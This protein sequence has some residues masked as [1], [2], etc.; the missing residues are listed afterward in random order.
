M[1][2]YFHYYEECSEQIYADYPTCIIVGDRT[3]D[4]AGQN[5]QK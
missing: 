1:F 3:N 2:R 5:G 4:G